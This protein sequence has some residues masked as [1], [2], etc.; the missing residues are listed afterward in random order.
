MK[1]GNSLQERAGSLLLSIP[2]WPLTPFGTVLLIVFALGVG[3]GVYEWYVC[4]ELRGLR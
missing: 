1:T 3:F 2:R 4:C